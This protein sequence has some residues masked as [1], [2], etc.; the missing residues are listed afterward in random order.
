[1]IS[2]G[3]GAG[4]K[5]PD[6]EAASAV[7]DGLDIGRASATLPVSGECQRGSGLHAQ[8]KSVTDLL[9]VGGPLL[10]GLLDGV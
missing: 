4:V 8:T 2:R 7:A 10:C 5:A 6:R 3:H 9:F 1:M